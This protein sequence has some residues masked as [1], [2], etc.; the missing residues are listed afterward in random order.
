MCMCVCRDQTCT[1][2]LDLYNKMKSEFS[3]EEEEEVSVCVCVC[4][5]NKYDLLTQNHC[6]N[7]KAS[8]SLLY[9]F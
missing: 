1:D 7:F 9:I 2:I 4:V 5:K 3:S 6:D 8:Y